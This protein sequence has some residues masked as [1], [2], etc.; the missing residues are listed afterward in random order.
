[1][2]ADDPLTRKNL[3]RRDKFKRILATIELKKLI[4]DMEIKIITERIKDEEDK[5]KKLKED[6]SAGKYKF[7]EDI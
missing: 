6:V 2:A 4:R 5:L 7:V 3:T 1:M